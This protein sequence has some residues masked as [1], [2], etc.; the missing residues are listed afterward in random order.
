MHGELC[1]AAPSSSR[2][3]RPPTLAASSAST[4][5]VSGP[6]TMSAR[7]C[8][9]DLREPP[10]MY[11]AWHVRRFL[12]GVQV[13]HEC[14]AWLRSRPGGVLPKP[15]SCCL[16]AVFPHGHP[17]DPPP[18]L[19]RHQGR[20]AHHARLHAAAL[21][22]A[23]NGVHD[24]RLAGAGARPKLGRQGGGG[25]GAAAAARLAA[26]GAL[27][28]A[29]GREGGQHEAC[30]AR[31]GGVEELGRFSKKQAFAVSTQGGTA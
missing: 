9:A 26:A 4:T 8:S 29:D 19:T 23:G 1:R 27:Q 15:P 17:K 7:R 13:G 18:K 12:G 31:L 24:V 14:S 5:R 10:A 25:A 16:L 6:A 11:S 22:A 20:R 3:E 28:V 30:R 2:R 21:H